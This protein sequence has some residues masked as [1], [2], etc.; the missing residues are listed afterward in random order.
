MIR[1]YQTLRTK[2][3]YIGSRTDIHISDV[4]FK[5]RKIILLNDSLYIIPPVTTH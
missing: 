2:Y 1:V 5:S 3:V 4:V